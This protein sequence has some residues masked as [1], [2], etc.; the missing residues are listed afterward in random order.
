VNLLDSLQVGG[1]VSLYAGFGVDNL[2]GLD[3]G[4]V[5]AGTYTLID[6]TL[7]TGVFAGLDHNSLGTAYDAGFGRT[8]YFQE[9]SLQLVVDVIP[10]PSA[11]LLGGLGM[12][13][14]LRRRRR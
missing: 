2:T 9:G 8:A 14:L 7:S 11:A 5:S 10:E 6:G 3:W 13:L 1:T 12:L 4:T